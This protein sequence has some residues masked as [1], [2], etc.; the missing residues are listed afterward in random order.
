ME[1]ST[2]HRLGHML[3]RLPAETV[4]IILFVPYHYFH[5]PIPGSSKDTKW[6][7]CKRRITALSA[8][9]PNSNVIDF[10]IQ[11]KITLEDSNYWD[12]LHFN[13]RIAR[14]LAGMIAD[15][16]RAKAGREG[17]FNYLTREEN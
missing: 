13:S 14:Q 6:N 9:H 8:S 16:V 11:S 7:E 15:G 4:K 3:A 1:F 10:M 17:Y 12:P 2:H 5:Q